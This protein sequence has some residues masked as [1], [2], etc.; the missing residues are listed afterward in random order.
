[1]VNKLNPSFPLPSPFNLDSF[2]GVSDFLTTLL[3]SLQ[4]LEREQTLV[5]NGLIDEQTAPMKPVGL[6][7][8]VKTALPAASLYTGAM[9]FVTNDVG[10]ST[11]AFSDG[12][13]WRR[14]ADRAVIS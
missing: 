4:G 5:I 3:Q 13:N 8:Y 1:M 9:I 6:K 10:G 7:S 11:P 14:V 12:T 2:R